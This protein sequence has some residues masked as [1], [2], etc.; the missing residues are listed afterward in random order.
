MAFTRRA[1]SLSVF[2]SFGG[3]DYQSEPLNF[4]VPSTSYLGAISLSVL[5][6]PGFT[7][8]VSALAVGD[9]FTVLI[10]FELRL[11]VRGLRCNV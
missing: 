4:G 5:S 11:D 7:V 6:L 10:G 1:R 9:Y 8:K 3:V 2:I